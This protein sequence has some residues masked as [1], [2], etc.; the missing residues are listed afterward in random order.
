MIKDKRNETTITKDAAAPQF[1]TACINKMMHLK[2][3][4][5]STF[6]YFVMG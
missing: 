2:N 6:K 1:R 4:S 5:R 3:S